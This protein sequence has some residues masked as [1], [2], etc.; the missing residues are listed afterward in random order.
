M[1][2][3][4]STAKRTT[5]DTQ[6][7][8]WEVCLHEI[9]HA[10]VARELGWTGHQVRVSRTWLGGVEGYYDGDWL[11]RVNGDELALRRAAVALGG[12]EVSRR[13]SW[14]FLPSGCNW[15]LDLAHTVVRGTGVT[16]GQAQALAR[17]LVGR[18]WSVIEREA[19]KLYLANG[20]WP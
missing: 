15:D 20:V 7:Q 13:H 10:I 5:V 9:G 12:P 2:W 14:L 19:R 8:E 6:S 11:R 18:R 17:K 4:S 3:L 16:Y 1:S